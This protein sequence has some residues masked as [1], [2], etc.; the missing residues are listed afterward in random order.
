MFINIQGFRRMLFG[1]PMP[2]K[3]DPKYRER[4]E[5]DVAA[6]AKFARITGIAWLGRHYVAW[7][8]KH[9]KAFF[10]IVLAVMTMF[11]IGNMYR[12]CVSMSGSTRPHSGAVVQQDS[13]LYQRYMLNHKK[14]I[15]YEKD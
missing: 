9:K 8:E 10:A 7:A 14:Q 2:D 6:G 15:A 1:E 4:Y 13:A 11:A 5:R 12:L 3:N